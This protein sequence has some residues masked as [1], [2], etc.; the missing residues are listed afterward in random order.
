MGVISFDSR[1]SMLM[2]SPARFRISPSSET[3]RATPCS[4][5][6]P[7]TWSGVFGGEPEHPELAVLHSAFEGDFP[8][9]PLASGDLDRCGNEPAPA[10]A[11]PGDVLLGDPVT[12]ADEDPEFV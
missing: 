8:D 7:P 2:S 9:A 6:P 10:P 11:G 12:L 4:E 5:P 1:L 3:P